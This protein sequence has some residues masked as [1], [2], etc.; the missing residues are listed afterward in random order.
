MQDLLIFSASSPVVAIAT[1]TVM[2]WLTKVP[3]SV[4]GVALCILFSAGT[5]LYAACVHLM[6]NVADTST[7]TASK[8]AVL[9]ASA[10]VPCFINGAHAHAH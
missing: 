9:V 3:S 10:I 7:F 8:L 4:T 1:Y 6:P 5:F 2:Q